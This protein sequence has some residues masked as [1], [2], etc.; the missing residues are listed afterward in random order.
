MCE[1]PNHS[2]GPAGKLIV[3]SGPSGVGKS[4]ITEKVLQQTDVAFS[5]SVTTRS[6]REDE[7]DG[8]HYSFVSVERFRQMVDDGA[9]LEWAEVFG[10][11]YGT[12]TEPVDAAVAA[13]Q[14]VVLEIDVQ[15]GIQVAA[16]RPEAVAILI[17][18]PDHEQLQERLTGRATDAAH[19]IARRLAKAQAEIQM[20]RESG[21]YT[22]EVV[23]DDLAQAVRQV[24]T[25]IEQESKTHD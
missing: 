15:G 24:M 3:I 1:Q 7:R 11:Y 22:H 13:G 16:K 25:I 17:L 5:V 21:A 2:D 8:E 12:P 4:S 10:N 18:P 19:V 23:N 20:A 14:T 9:L 6:P